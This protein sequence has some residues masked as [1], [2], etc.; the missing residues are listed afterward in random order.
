MSVVFVVTVTVSLL[1]SGARLDLLSST[2]V[3]C[4]VQDVLPGAC[5]NIECS[6]LRHDDAPEPISIECMGRKL[7]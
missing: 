2:A 3:G 5:N 4:K 7:K 1:I 6:L